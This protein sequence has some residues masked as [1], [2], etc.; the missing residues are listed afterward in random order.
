MKALIRHRVVIA[1]SIISCGLMGCFLVES[2]QKPNQGAVKGKAKKVPVAAERLVFLSPGD[3]ATIGKVRL[4][5]LGG[6][7]GKITS[8]GS[9]RDEYTTKEDFFQLRISIENLSETKILNYHPWSGGDISFGLEDRPEVTDEH[10]NRYTR[11]TGGLSSRKTAGF[12]GRTTRVDPGKSIDDTFA[13]ERPVDR[14]TMFTVKFTG[15][16]VGDSSANATYKIPRSFF[17][18]RSEEGKAS[19]QNKTGVE[20][21]DRFPEA[22]RDKLIEEWDNEMRVLDGTLG[23]NLHQLKKAKTVKERQHIQRLI[24]VNSAKLQKHKVNDP[25]YISKDMQKVIN[26]MK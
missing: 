21:Y 16:N 22:V 23:D 24:T 11:Y 13:F 8:Q 14:A 17:E 15:S 26:E 10:G 3:T 2:P 4:S 19:P 1:L 18:A 5:I 9:F 6:S 25:P 20:A 12:V 7:V